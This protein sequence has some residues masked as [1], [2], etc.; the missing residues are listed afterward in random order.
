MLKY[1]TL[2]AL[3]C[4]LFQMPAQ[5]LEEGPLVI[6]HMNVG[7][8]DATRFNDQPAQFCEAQR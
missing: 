2:I 5:A 4:L 3:V 6:L 8:G 7:Q 1:G